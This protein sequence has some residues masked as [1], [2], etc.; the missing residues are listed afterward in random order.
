[1][2]TN[3]MREL[4]V[5]TITASRPIADVYITQLIL[6]PPQKM[7]RIVSIVWLVGS[8]ACLLLR[9]LQSPDENKN[10]DEEEEEWET[11]AFRNDSIRMVMYVIVSVDIDEAHCVCK[12]LESMN[13]IQR[14]DAIWH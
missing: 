10:M 11:N 8:I 3:Y 5:H 13:F 12:L 2:D 9:Y 1:M 14:V 6:L 7:F 4:Q